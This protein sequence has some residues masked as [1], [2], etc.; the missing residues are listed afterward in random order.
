MESCFF[1]D[2]EFYPTVCFEIHPGG[3][4]W[5]QVPHFYCYLVLINTSLVFFRLYT[6]SYPFYPFGAVELLPAFRSH[7]N[8]ALVVLHLSL[9]PHPG[10]FLGHTLWSSVGRP[11][12]MQCSTL[13]GNAKL[14]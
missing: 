14:F 12:N 8:A 1:S 10:V 2:L 3:C 7:E 9:I 11:S 4:M 13:F 6:T 5:L